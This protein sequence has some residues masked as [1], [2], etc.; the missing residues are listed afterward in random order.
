M[1]NEKAPHNDEDLDQDQTLGSVGPCQKKS[2][3]IEGPKEELE[4][5][6]E[7]YSISKPY[8]ITIRAK[9]V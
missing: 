9:I 1:D 3:E 8:R 7:R 5:E 6:E 2:K 4:I